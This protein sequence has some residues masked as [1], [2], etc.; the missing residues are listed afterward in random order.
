MAQFKLVYVVINYLTGSICDERMND[1]DLTLNVNV[2]SFFL[3][4]K[5]K[6][7]KH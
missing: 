4:T 3:L 7:T 6:T 2:I 1:D 5:K